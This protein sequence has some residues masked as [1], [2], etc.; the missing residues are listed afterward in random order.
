MTV[1]LLLIIILLTIG[2]I[3]TLIKGID[4]WKKKID[5]KESHEKNMWLVAF[6]IITPILII[7]YL[8]I[9]LVYHNA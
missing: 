8:K 1:I 9:K 3:A 2:D 7:T 4:D 6:Y 5:N